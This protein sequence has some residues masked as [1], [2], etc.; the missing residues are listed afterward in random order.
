MGLYKTYV[1]AAIERLVVDRVTVHLFVRGR[2]SP[3]DI[4][5][6]IHRKNF[7]CLCRKGPTGV[8]S[9]ESQ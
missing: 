6:E 2:V 9:A 8:S 3:L 7:P 1:V 5:Y 4:F